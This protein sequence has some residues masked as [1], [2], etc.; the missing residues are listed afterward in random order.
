MLRLKN[1]FWYQN[2]TEEQ[3]TIKNV[4]SVIKPMLN[5]PKIVLLRNMTSVNMP[6]LNPKHNTNLSVLEMLFRNGNKAYETARP[7]RMYAMEIA[8][9]AMRI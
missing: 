1:L 7:G 5:E 4:E 8:I 3:K 9:S 2:R 6:G